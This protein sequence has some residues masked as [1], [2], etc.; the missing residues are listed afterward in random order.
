MREIFEKYSTGCIAAAPDFWG[1]IDVEAA[2]LAARSLY[3]AR[4]KTAAAWCAL[5]ARSDG[6]SGDFSFW[7][8]V[9]RHLDAEEIGG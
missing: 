8:Q 1:N 2:T 6:R 9:F 4:A 3:G 7:V 5:S